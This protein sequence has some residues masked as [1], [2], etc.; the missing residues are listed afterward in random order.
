MK[1]KLTKFECLQKAGKLYKGYLTIEKAIEF[2]KFEYDW[3]IELIE[4]ETKNINIEFCKEHNINPEYMIFM[5]NLQES[6]EVNM[7]ASTKIIMQRLLLDRKEA[8]DLLKNYIAYYK[9]IF[10]P[11]NC[12]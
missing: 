12:I 7:V 6:G 3:D 2:L 10:T 11:Y 8:F 4:D 9:E 1:R 5:K